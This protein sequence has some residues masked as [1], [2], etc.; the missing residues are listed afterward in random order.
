MW[1]DLIPDTDCLGIEREHCNVDVT[2]GNYVM[3][4]AF[5][6]L[7]ESHT[8]H[9][10]KYQRD[11]VM[12]LPSTPTFGTSTSSTRR[13]WNCQCGRNVRWMLLCLMATATLAKG[14]VLTYFYLCHYDCTCF[15]NAFISY[16]R[17]RALR[18]FTSVP[19]MDIY[20]ALGTSL[21]KTP[22]FNVNQLNR[23]LKTQLNR[24]WSF[25]PRTS[26]SCGMQCLGSDCTTVWELWLDNWSV[27]SEGNPK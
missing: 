22:I 13:Q 12:P 15:I 20:G 16:A 24:L 26:C 21:W 11:A 4:M 17:H 10:L 5:W 3:A 23:Q 1:L 2:P 18:L 9:G 14:T 27:T 25:Q 8:E 6:V 7:V 19:A